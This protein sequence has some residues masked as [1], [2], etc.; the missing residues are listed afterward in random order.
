MTKPKKVVAKRCCYEHWSH[1][2]KQMVRCG[3]PAV[4]QF[5]KHYLCDEHSTQVSKYDLKPIKE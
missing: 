4:F 1:E 5:G 3:K 2:S